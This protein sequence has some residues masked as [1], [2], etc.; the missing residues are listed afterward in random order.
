M[1]VPQPGA[2]EIEHTFATFLSLLNRLNDTNS[3]SLSHV[4]DGETT[5][6]WVL[7]IRLHTHWLAGD[8]LDDARITR[9]HELGG[10][11]DSLACSA[12]D[13]LK[14]FGEFAGNVGRMAIEDRSI[15]G[16]NLTGMVE[17][18]DLGVEGCSLLGGVILGVR[19]DIT[20]ADILDR[21]VPE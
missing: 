6:R 5:K 20:A 4:T 13:L 14:K 15:A 21:H 18:D 1:L 19:S 12:I 11:L 2:G 17:D 9:L 3:N 10:L 16:T 8:E 7:R